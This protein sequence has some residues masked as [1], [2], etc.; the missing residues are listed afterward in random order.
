M[1][2]NLVFHSLADVIIVR[3][4]RLTDT[5]FFI[6]FSQARDDIAHISFDHFFIINGLSILP[7]VPSGRVRMVVKAMTEMALSFILREWLYSR[8]AWVRHQK[9]PVRNKPVSTN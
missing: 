4:Q 9:Y 5:E 8:A 3:H 7:V 2:V 6:Y 1:P